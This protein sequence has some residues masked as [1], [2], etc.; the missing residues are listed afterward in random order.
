MQLQRPQIL[1]FTSEIMLIPCVQLGTKV[2]LWD[3]FVVN[4]SAFKQIQK[5]E[6]KYTLSEISAHSYQKNQ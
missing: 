6:N 1:K 5:K 2:T 4:N 3:N